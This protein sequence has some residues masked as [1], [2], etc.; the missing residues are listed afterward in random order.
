M[1]LTDFDLS[2]SRFRTDEEAHVALRHACATNPDLA[3]FHDLG[4]SEEGRPICGVTL[5]NGPETVSLVAGAHADEPVGPETLRTF[6][7]GAL[8]H[9]DWLAEDGGFRELLERFTFRV[10]PQVNPDAELR[11]RSW[12]DAW[13]DV[14]SYLRHRAREQ[15][16]R[17]L[18]FGFPVMR[19]E[20]RIASRFLFDFTPLCLHMSLHGMGF[21]EGAMLLIERGWVDHTEVLREAFVTSAAEAGLGLHDHDRGGEKGFDYVD[22]GFSTTPQGDAMRAYFQAQGDVEMARKFF[23]S[24]MELARVAGYD[25]ER[26]RY[27]LCLVTE[28]PLF[29]IERPYEHEPGVPSAYLA[30][31][32]ELPELQLRLRRGESVGETLEPYGLRPLDLETAVRLQL[33]CIELGLKCALKSSDGETC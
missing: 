7:L 19:R 20:N 4:T 18:E 6:V 1:R 17:D 10:I 24:S 2:G 31:R 28:L 26:Q 29:V 13:P 23:F 15:P 27:P 25:A 33:R 8:A 21:S 22:P 14:E 16:G 3:H 11:N 9:R 30:F 12:I 32:D 5:G